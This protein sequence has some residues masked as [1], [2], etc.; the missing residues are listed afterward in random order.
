MIHLIIYV[1]LLINII[2][3]CM[4]HVACCMYI[5]M[6]QLPDFKNLEKRLTLLFHEQ[7]S[8]RPA[9]KKTKIFRN[10]REGDTYTTYCAD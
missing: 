4:M 1:V 6:C 2:P 5:K 8:T 10:T 3:R 9:K 7:L